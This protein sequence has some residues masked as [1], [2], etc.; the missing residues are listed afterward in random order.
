MINGI[1]VIKDRDTVLNHKLYTVHAIERNSEGL[2]AH[3]VWW[4][5]GVDHVEDNPIILK[6]LAKEVM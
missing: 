5:N 3:A 2:I 4:W 6:R 1:F